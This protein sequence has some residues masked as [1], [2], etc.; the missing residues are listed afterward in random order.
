MTSPYLARLQAK[1]DALRADISGVQT[2]ATD[3]D[4]DLTEDEL[5]TVG[6]QAAQAKAIYAQIEDATE[7]EARNRKVAELAASLPKVEEA[8]AVTETR[9]T[10]NAVVTARDPG[11]YR[12]VEE[13]G[14]NSFFGDMYRAKVLG[15]VDAT[16]RLDEHTRA[17]T[18]ATGG[19]G[20][21][22][23][24][25]LV[26]EYMAIARQTRAVANAVRHLPLGR[27]PRPIVLPK[28][29]QGI[30]AS[31][32]N[33]VAQAAEGANTA[34]WGADKF[35]SNTDTLTPAAYAAYQD[36]SRQLLD[37]SDP[38]ID[39][40]VF[41]DLRAAWDTLIEGL[42]CSAILAGGTATGTTWAT[43]TAWKA[44]TTPTSPLDAIVDAQ[45]AVA[46]DQRG[47]A[48]LVITN[49]KR[50][51]EFR[52]LKDSSN[53]PLMPVSRY[54]PQNAMG[55]LDNLLVGDIEGSDVLA[56]AGVATA[57]LEKYAVLRRNAV[58]L[59]ES[60]VLDFTYD[61]VA[62]PSAVR[63]GI[64]GYVGTLVRNPNSV[65]VQVITSSTT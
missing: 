54:G 20:I 34:A 29:T 57:V 35:T 5:R 60:D 25:W 16:K 32:S 58:I 49:F 44:G 39:A 43:Q 19:T 17:V 8:P 48:D 24:K 52:K 15:N 64:W 56:S 46:G 18:Q 12:S 28:Q 36:V 55:T 3:A 6:E 61:Q 62:G 9:S 13:G 37:S 4:R 2:R 42:V 65:S 51:G 1:Y 27:D 14:Q 38:A 63:M 59:A 11:H 26:A 53:R 7:V 30:D 22:P 23:P 47:M 41:G 50:F 10:G 33:L 21:I 45:T 40:L 31:P